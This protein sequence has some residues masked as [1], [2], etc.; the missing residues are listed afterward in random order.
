MTVYNAILKKKPPQISQMV[1][2]PLRPDSIFAI[3]LKDFTQIDVL[4][5]R[6]YS[7]AV[8][9]ICVAGEFTRI[10]DPKEHD[11]NLKFSNKSRNQI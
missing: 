7:F 3:S 2:E 6:M 1:E 4:G 9:K 10:G 5:K 11:T 8:Q